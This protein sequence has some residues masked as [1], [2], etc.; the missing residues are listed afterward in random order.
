MEGGFVVDDQRFD[1]ET[2]LRIVFE[3]EE[4]LRAED[5]RGH[6]RNAMAGRSDALLHRVGR[7]ERAQDDPEQLHDL[8]CSARNFPGRFA[9]A[10]SYKF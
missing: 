1:V 9:G 6:Q 4:G 7:E 3:Q 2:Q 8:Q 5:L 10:P